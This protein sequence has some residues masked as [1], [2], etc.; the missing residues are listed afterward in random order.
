[1]KHQQQ[2]EKE[3]NE[4]NKEKNNANLMSKTYSMIRFMFEDNCQFIITHNVFLVPFVILCF[5][6]L[7][8]WVYIFYILCFFYRKK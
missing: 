2:K 4:Y 7:H 6:F 1:M 5:F 8:I 3:E